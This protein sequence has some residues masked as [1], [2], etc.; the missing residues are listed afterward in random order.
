MATVGLL[1]ASPIHSDFGL[2]YRSAN[3]LFT[4]SPAYNVPNLNPPTLS[5]LMAPLFK[6]SLPSAWF[7]WSIAGCFGIAISMAIARRT[8]ALS[9][10]ALL[11]TLGACGALAG[12]SM[13]WHLG[14]IT[15][16]VLPF[17]TAAW[18]DSRR[19]RRI[20]AGI[21]LGIAIAIKPPLLLVAICMPLV[22]AG[23]ATFTAVAVTAAGVLSTGLAPW[24]GW[25]R[26]SR[27]INWIGQPLNASL[28]GVAARTSTGRSVGFAMAQFGITTF[29]AIAVIAIAMAWRARHA[30]DDDRWTLALLLSIMVSPLGWAYYVPLLLFPSAAAWR[31]TGVIAAGLLCV[32]IPFPWISGAN[33]DAVTVLVGLI[34]PT[35][36]AIAWFA[37]SSPLHRQ[38]APTATRAIA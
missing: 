13:A 33:G 19:D 36:L 17:I 34:Y 7:A 26:L 24:L 22:V 5:L 21:W 32:P 23:S 38:H 9:P 1:T 30:D 8:A 35:A 37:W 12:S 3:A 20:R 16:I 11:W 28:F 29:V 15:W 25:I 6:L 10:E 18:A 14:Q 2:I 31:K 27:T 4:R